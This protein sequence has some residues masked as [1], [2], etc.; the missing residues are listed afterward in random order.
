MRL[1]ELVSFTM[2]DHESVETGDLLVRT[3]KILYTVTSMELSA[4][5]SQNTLSR[6]FE[7]SPLEEDSQGADL[8]NLRHQNLCWNI[9]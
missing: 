7:R 3:W 5:N 1:V 2:I 4:S 8:H 9:Q 6:R